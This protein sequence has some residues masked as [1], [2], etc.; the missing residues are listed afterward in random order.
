MTIV[1]NMPAAAYHA[2]PGLSSTYLRRVATSSVVH[3]R[4]PVAESDEMRIGTA[5]HAVILDG[6]SIADVLYAGD[7][8]S[9]TTNAGRAL[10]A[11]RASEDAYRAA[12]AVADGESIS[13]AMREAAGGRICLRASEDAEIRELAA[14]IGDRIV[15]PADAV[16]RVD[17]TCRAL[18]AHPVAALL[19][20]CEREATAM[21][22]DDYAGSCKARLDALQAEHG[23]VLDL[24]TTSR[25]A[26]P[27]D[28]GRTSVYAGPQYAIQAAHYIRGARAAGADATRAIW[29]VA[30]TTAP[31]GI[32]LVEASPEVL[33]WA[34]SRWRVAVDAHRA[35]REGDRPYP[36][37]PIWVDLPRYLST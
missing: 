30:E 24:K 26:R 19:A 20:T 11:L 2:A 18:A 21:W 25:T 36:D 16:A 14:R 28:W 4:L 7:A 13:K 12:V 35:Y 8:P 9:G 1:R 31:H 6:A 17:G 37:D 34:A 5:I 27:D 23:I 15:L 29:V 33:D 22:N 32:G 10:A 3:A